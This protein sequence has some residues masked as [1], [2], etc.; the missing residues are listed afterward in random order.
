M[1]RL[2]SRKA[3]IRL[4][5][6]AVVAALS[7]WGILNLLR[8][9]ADWRF[10]DLSDYRQSIWRHCH[11]NDLPTELVEAVIE[12]ESGGNARAVS[13]AKAKGLMQITDITHHEVMNKTS[14]GDGDLFDPDYNILVGTT[15]LRMLH[16]RFDGDPY[17]VLAAYNAGPTAV[18]RLRRRHPDLSSEQLVAQHAP[19]ETAAYC[20]R[21]LGGS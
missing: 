17:L 1:K 21:I 5:A 6:A 3:L 2:H 10:E 20:R 8:P 13:R 12:T 18:A 9:R 7:T 15:Y 11:D 14:V 16:D 4:A 19:A